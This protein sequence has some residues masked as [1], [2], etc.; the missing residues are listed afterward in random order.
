MTER[1]E[2]GMALDRQY[3][4]RATPHLVFFFAFSF[5]GA[6]RGGRDAEGPGLFAKAVTFGCPGTVGSATLPLKRLR[7]SDQFAAEKDGFPPLGIPCWRG[8]LGRGFPKGET[9]AGEERH[10]L[11]PRA[12]RRAGGGYD[13]SNRRRALR[14]DAKEIT[15]PFSVTPQRSI[16]KSPEALLLLQAL[17]SKQAQPLSSLSFA[18]FAPLR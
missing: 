6:P 3:M 7:R 1:N 18:S 2:T 13:Q 10:G 17:N 15:L 8:R 16:P 4:S 9:K 5:P 11:C 14:G 12:F